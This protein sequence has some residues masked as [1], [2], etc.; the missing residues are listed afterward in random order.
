MSAP[1]PTT[2]SPASP[3]NFHA[4]AVGLSSPA[5]D[6]EPPGSAG[7]GSTV[8]GSSSIDHQTPI[9]L[10]LQNTGLPKTDIELAIWGSPAG[11]HMRRP[12][13]ENLAIFQRAVGINSNSNSNRD[14]SSG[15]NNNNNNRNSNNRNR[16]SNNR[17]APPTTDAAS[18]E[19]GQ[20]H[21]E[22]PAIPAAPAAPAAALEKGCRPGS[23]YA[24][25]RAE[26]R[27]KAVLFH[28]LSF[29]INAGHVSQI[30]I[31]AS[32]TAL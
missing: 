13:D 19:V 28:L 22:T 16:N 3:T 5:P 11:L 7:G 23:I 6:T 29:V 15:S 10:G 25:A 24:A 27:R 4:P 30:V 1:Q 17:P 8:I 21:I 9:G 12:N 32:L 26:V 20:Q 18:L 14:S 2:F 31:G